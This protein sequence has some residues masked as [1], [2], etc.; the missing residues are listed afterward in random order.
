MQQYHLAK[1]KSNFEIEFLFVVYLSKQQ[2]IKKKIKIKGN[3]IRPAPV[4]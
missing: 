1:Y 2:S 4:Q 3:V